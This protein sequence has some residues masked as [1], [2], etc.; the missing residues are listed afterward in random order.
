M[1]NPGYMVD[2]SHSLADRPDHGLGS[3]SPPVH[4]GLLMRGVRTPAPTRPRMYTF[5]GST[6]GNQ[7]T[8]Q[9]AIEFMDERGIF[10][11]YSALNDKAVSITRSLGQRPP[12]AC[13]CSDTSTYVV[14]V[15][16]SGIS[17]Q[18]EPYIPAKGD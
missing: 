7:M 13:E 14:V 17:H 8:I 12:G 4:V 3:G 15:H 11:G 2:P 10:S 1:P 6:R 9:K 16:H 5:T 18:P